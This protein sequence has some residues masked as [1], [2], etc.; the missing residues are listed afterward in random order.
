MSSRARLSA[1]RAI[2]GGKVRCRPSIFDQSTR[3]A[4]VLP[5]RETKHSNHARPGGS[6]SLQSFLVVIAL[7]AARLTRLFLRLLVTG[8]LV[9]RW[10]LNFFVSLVDPSPGLW[11]V[12]LCLSSA[13][14][15]N[16]L[17]F[18]GM[19]SILLVSVLFL[20][21]TPSQLPSLLGGSIL[22]PLSGW[23]HLRVSWLPMGFRIR[24]LQVAACN[25]I[26]SILFETLVVRILLERH[27]EESALRKS[28]VNSPHIPTDRRK[29]RVTIVYPHEE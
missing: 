8:R 27:L 1:R 7:L 25:G 5:L 29:F 12:L 2:R 22:E 10:S 11:L 13:V 9:P 20:T 4:W 19:A 24:L 26:L 15:T 23:L 21:V 3:L 17:C 14:W 16:R 28:R 6:D 18:G